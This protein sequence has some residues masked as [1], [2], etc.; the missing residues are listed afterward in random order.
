MCSIIGSFDRDHFKSLVELNRYRGEHSHS[1]AAVDLDAGLI[2]LRR[3]FGGIDLTWADKIFDAN[4]EAYIVGHMQAPTTDAKDA[5]AIH[6]SADVKANTAYLWHN[7][8]I[9]EDCIAHMQR[10]LG[11]NEE[12]DT[13]L[14]NQWISGRHKLDDVDGSFACLR[15]DVTNGLTMFRNALSPL[16]VDKNLNLSSTK[17]AAGYDVPDGFVWHLDLHR[18]TFYDIATFTTKNT[19]YVDITDL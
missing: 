3:G 9:K 16:F 14:L 10:T 13:A 18:R 11:V 15:Y 7:G 12:W 17:F 1:L 2:S 19:F 6:P 8:I 5:T 4:P